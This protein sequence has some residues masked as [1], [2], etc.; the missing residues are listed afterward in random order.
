MALIGFD[1]PQSRVHGSFRHFRGQHAP[2]FA[3]QRQSEIAVAA[4]KL[5]HIATQTFGAGAGP[6]QHFFAHFGIGLGETALDL[7][8]AKSFVA[9]IELFGNEILRQHHFLATAAPDNPHAQLRLQCFGGG[10]PF[11]I[12]LFVVNHR[13]QHLAA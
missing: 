10:A 2:K 5:E 13:H 8:V 6:G 4:I 3:R 1:I 7:A 11:V 9:H 12:Q